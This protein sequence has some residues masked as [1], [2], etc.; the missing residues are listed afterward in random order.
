MKAFARGFYPQ[1]SPIHRL[2]MPVKLPNSI[3]SSP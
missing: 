1:L 2:K 3:P